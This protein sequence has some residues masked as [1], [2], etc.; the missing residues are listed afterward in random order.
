ML[1]LLQ[2][3]DLSVD[4]E[5][6]TD[7]SIQTFLARALPHARWDKKRPTVENVLNGFEI[8][9]VSELIE[10]SQSKGWWEK[11]E[12]RLSAKLGDAAA[13]VV[14]LLKKKQSGL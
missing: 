8:L 9:T 5:T 6:E 4:F 14:T 10:V 1:P 11:V 13:T 12:D 3:K 2:I 7:T